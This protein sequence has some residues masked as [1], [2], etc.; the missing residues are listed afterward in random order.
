MRT[1]T[2]HIVVNALTNTSLTFD[3]IWPATLARTKIMSASRPA[4]QFQVVSMAF[5]L[6]KKETR[7]M[8]DIKF[9]K[10]KEK[11]HEI[12]ALWMNKELN[13]PVVRSFDPNGQGNSDD[14][15]LKSKNCVSNTEMESIQFH[16]FPKFNAI[17]ITTRQSTVIILFSNRNEMVSVVSNSRNVSIHCFLFVQRKT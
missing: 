5:S 6:L 15:I 3:S 7:C 2:L 17:T 9:A 10:R 11:R 4:R 13:C 12:G 1:Q 14:A 8:H 16:P